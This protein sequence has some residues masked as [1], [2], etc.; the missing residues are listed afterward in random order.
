MRRLAISGIVALI[1]VWALLPGTAAHANPPDIET[2]NVNFT[3]QNAS[4]TGACGFPVTR[5]T[6][7]HLTFRWFYDQQNNLVRELGNGILRSTLSANGN[8][9]NVQ[10]AGPDRAVWNPDG[11]VTVSISGLDALIIIPGVGYSYGFVGLFVFNLGPGGTTVLQ[12]IGWSDFDKTA[13]CT[14]LSQ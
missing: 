5:H 6:E 9:V 3:G 10:Y 8:S 7:G 2:M 1:S 4:W 12:E 14:Y 11:S 13:V